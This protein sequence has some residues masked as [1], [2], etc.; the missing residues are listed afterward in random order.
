SDLYATRL[1]P[2]TDEATLMVTAALH[3]S[4]KASPKTVHATLAASRIPVRAASAAFRRVA[5]PLGPISRRQGAVNRS[6]ASLL[7]RLNR[8]EISI[9]PPLHDPT[10]MVSIDQ[11]S[12]PL[13]PPGLPPWVWLLLARFWWLLLLLGVIA[14]ALGILLAV[15]GV[16]WLAGALIGLGLLLIAAGFLVRGRSPNWTV[17]VGV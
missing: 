16:A 8:G 2:L 5:R 17:A 14:L 1:Q 10:G 11:I 15:A 12:D 6:P 13:F 3:T 7:A 9:A 4:L